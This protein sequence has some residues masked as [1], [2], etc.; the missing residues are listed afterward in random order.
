MA[1]GTG[2]P[3]PE[4]YIALSKLIARMNE[5]FEGDLSD[6]DK[7]AYVKHI[8]GKMMEDETLAQQATQNTKE[9]FEGGH[10]KKALMDAVVEGFDNYKSMAEQVMASDHVKQDFAKIV[11]DV[12]Y[13][14]LKA[15]GVSVGSSPLP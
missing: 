5:L 11:L 8:A 9:Q 13:D 6:A 3:R 15:K 7:V 12:V 10:F 4:E 1:P 2:E 14:G